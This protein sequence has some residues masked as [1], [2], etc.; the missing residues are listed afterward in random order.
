MIVRTILRTAIFLSAGTSVRT[1]SN[2]SFSSAASSPPPAA[3][4]PAT[5]IATGALLASTPN[6]SSIFETSS[7]ASTRVRPLMS[8][9][10]ESTDASMRTDV[11][12]AGGAMNPATATALAAMRRRC[13]VV[14]V[15]LRVCMSLRVSAVS[16]VVVRVCALQGC[17]GAACVLA[18][19]CA[20]CGD[21]RFSANRRS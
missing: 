10:M 2:S 13:M 16:A 11:G 15:F 5:A 4:P 20:G 7:D 9:R 14:A 8:S 21:G 19:E 12:R 1:T 3:A 17:V 18:R 6:V